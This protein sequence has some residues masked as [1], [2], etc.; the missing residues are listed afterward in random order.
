MRC[1]SESKISRE[2]TS[3]INQYG[4]RK[5][6]SRSFGDFSDNYNFLQSNDSIDNS[7]EEREKRKKMREDEY[8]KIMESSEEKSDF[9][10]DDKNCYSYSDR[11]ENSESKVSKSSSV[12]L[13]FPMHV[14]TQ[15]ANTYKSARTSHV[16][17]LTSATLEENILR[18]LEDDSSYDG[19]FGSETE[20]SKSV[21]YSRRKSVTSE[22]SLEGDHLR[23]QRSSL[24]SGGSS[25]RFEKCSSGG[26]VKFDKGDSADYLHRKAYI[27]AQ[28]GDTQKTG[29]WFIDTMNEM[30]D[31][32]CDGNEKEEHR[33]D[34]TVVNTSS[35]SIILNYGPL[36]INTI[37][38]W[39]EYLKLNSLISG[40]HIF[41]IY[42]GI[43]SM[44]IKYHSQKLEGKNKKAG[45]SATLLSLPTFP[46]ENE[47]DR[48]IPK[49][50]SNLPNLNVPTDSQ[51]TA[52]V[53]YHHN[54]LHAKEGVTIYDDDYDDFL[55]SNL[56]Y[57]IQR[58]RNKYNKFCEHVGERLEHIDR[59]N[60]TFKQYCFAVS[61]MF[62]QNLINIIPFSKVPGL[63]SHMTNSFHTCIRPNE[64]EESMTETDFMN[65]Y[66][67]QYSS[68]KM[69][70]AYSVPMEL[71][72]SMSNLS[73][74]IQM[75]C[76]GQTKNVFPHSNEAFS[77]KGGGSQ[78]FPR[79]KSLNVNEQQ[80]RHSFSQ[81]FHGTQRKSTILPGGILEE[82]RNYL[83]GNFNTLPKYVKTC[84]NSR[85]KL[86]NSLRPVD[87]IKMASV[88]NN[89]L[90]NVGTLRK[91][92][93]SYDSSGCHEGVPKVNTK[94]E[95]EEE[96]ADA[97]GKQLDNM[98]KNSFDELGESFNAT[99]NENYCTAKSIPLN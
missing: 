84:A 74:T 92:K 19:N 26:K 95:A 25:R 69:G 72:R 83:T 46:H 29:L 60:Y 16:L 42:E 78:I 33:N 68:S 30:L 65:T 90:I 17:K 73:T 58:M 10:N 99:T 4:E 11:S 55:F 79:R 63:L 28:M 23:H 71:D 66:N 34:G 20:K 93:S 1:N 91:C 53:Q 67:M 21:R 85:K 61:K 38:R 31:N 43:R 48:C 87:L 6:E 77:C 36:G 45:R 76:M 47:K 15:T 75:N 8:N 9:F 52:H 56:P 22:K 64:N 35:N 97:E 50:Y 40:I 70:T 82:R 62:L 89:A 2:M 41:P 24:K 7:F 57:L 86:S 51:H 81:I 96:E 88:K 80:R 14:D 32:L 94:A 5:K 18:N 37:L 3:G 98:Q 59:E 44:F 12:G 39:P 49:T 54:N 27:M 13:A